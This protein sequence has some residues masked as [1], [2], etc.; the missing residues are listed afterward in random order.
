MAVVACFA[1]LRPATSGI[2]I[3]MKVWIGTLSQRLSSFP[4]EVR[5]SVVCR[6]EC[7][8]K[9]LVG[10]CILYIARLQRTTPF[11]HNNDVL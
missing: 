5:T 9:P 6:S 7:C 8:Y 3:R 10:S 1:D 2:A 4:F 11:L